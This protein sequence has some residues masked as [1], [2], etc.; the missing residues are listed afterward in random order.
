MKISR[1][2][3][4]LTPEVLSATE[5]LSA[6]IAKKLVVKQGRFLKKE[7]RVKSCKFQ[8]NCN[9]QVFI[10]KLRVANYELSL[11]L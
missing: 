5:I 4:Q 9:L 11:D 3:V 10:L 2:K 7:S 1:A 6:S 8:Q